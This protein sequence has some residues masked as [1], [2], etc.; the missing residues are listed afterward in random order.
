MI[1]SRERELLIAYAATVTTTQ[2]IE[3]LELETLTTSICATQTPV[4]IT[5]T[6]STESIELETV[7]QTTNLYFTITQTTSIYSTTNGAATPTTLA[8]TE[9]MTATNTQ[10]GGLPNGLYLDSEHWLMTGS[11][12]CLSVCNDGYTDNNADHDSFLNGHSDYQYLH[13]H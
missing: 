8:K 7:T 2:S 3:T 5:T 13:Y 11:Y 6:Q 1:W 10:T 4:T 9:T 12:D